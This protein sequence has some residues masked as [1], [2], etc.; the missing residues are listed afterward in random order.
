MLSIKERQLNLKT[1]Y[2]LYRGSIDGIEGSNTKLSYRNF[3]SFTNL[4]VDGI[5]G[6][7]TDNKLREV[8]RDIQ[9][10]LNTKGYSLSVDGIVGNNTI[11]AI[12]DFQK[13]NNLV[14]DGIVGNKTMDKLKLGSYDWNQVKH[15]KKNEFT[16]KCGCKLNNTDL[17]LVKVLDSIRDHFNR[18][19]IISSGC[20]CTKHNREVGG[21]RNSKHLYGKAADI[22]VCN[23]S[24]ADVLNYVNTLVKSGRIRYAY[25]QTRNMGNAVHIDIN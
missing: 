15:F 18:P 4:K 5:Y 20:R 12:K 16:C 25:G 14:S 6:N 17:D 22:V 7:N 3:Q 13:K 11:N 8:I 21:V 10:R 24:T 9:S 19:I 1:Y 23:V 2:Y